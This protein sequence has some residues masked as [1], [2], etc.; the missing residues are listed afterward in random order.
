MRSGQAGDRRYGSKKT[1]EKI[2]PVWKHI[3]NDSSA[4]F[5]AVVPR[6]PLRSLKAAFKNPVA[7]VAS[8]GEYASQYAAL[9]YMLE[10]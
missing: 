1:L 7:K 6:R 8:H 9:N 5:L 2:L 10:F 3:Q 4:I